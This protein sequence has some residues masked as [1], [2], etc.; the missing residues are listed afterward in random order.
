MISQHKLLN[1]LDNGINGTGLLAESTVD[2]L[3]HINIVSSGSSASVSSL[4]GFN[5]DGLSIMQN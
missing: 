3:G 4:L 1:Y 5:G 2:A